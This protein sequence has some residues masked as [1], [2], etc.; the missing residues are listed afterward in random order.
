[1]KRVH[2][3][4][5]AV[6]AAFFGLC[7]FL[8]AQ[9]VKPA[10]VLLFT[11]SPG[12]PHGPA[13][14]NLKDGTTP[15]GRALNAYFKDKKIEIIESKDGSIFDGDLS[16][17]DGFV[18]STV[19]DLMGGKD[20][21]NTAANGFSAVDKPMTEKGLRNMIAAIRN[22]KGFMGWH[23][24]TDS[25]SGVK[26]EKGQ[27]IYTN[28]IGARFIVHGPDQVA[29]VTTTDA[30][31]FPFLKDTKEYAVHEEWYAMKNFNPDMHVLQVQKTKK[32]D[33]STAMNGDMYNRAPFPV[34][35]IRMEGK[36]RV[37]YTSFGHSEH[38]FETSER[39]MQKWG[40]L[41]PGITRLQAVAEL[42][43]WSI[44]RFDSDTTPNFDKV[45]PGAGEKN[46]REYR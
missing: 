24:A 31:K 19:A 36:G 9:E 15:A 13:N 43:E 14:A 12:F 35:W 28:L 18:F 16:Q 39:E 25:F 7:A 22:G 2:V 20:E 34:T 8:N 21:R 4:S 5:L 40:T 44:G 38:S 46:D 27:D 10:K 1:M 37:A 45:A 26:D 29:G 3:L 30:G 11:R 23:N 32:E 41:Q 42:I 6:C 33:G 17:Y